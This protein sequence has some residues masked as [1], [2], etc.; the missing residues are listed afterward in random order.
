[1][2][3]KELVAGC[4]VLARDVLVDSGRLFPCD[5]AKAPEELEASPERVER[6]DEGREGGFEGGRGRAALLDL[7]LMLRYFRVVGVRGAAKLS[8]AGGYWYENS[9]ISGECYVPFHPLRQKDFICI[10]QLLSQFAHV[11][12]GVGGGA[13][14]EQFNFFASGFALEIGGERHAASA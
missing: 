10:I 9:Y 1:M 7:M 11:G 14:N 2:P 4:S 12:A 8:R 3:A 13:P 5:S 6:E